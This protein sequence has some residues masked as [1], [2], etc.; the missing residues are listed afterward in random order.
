VLDLGVHLSPDFIVYKAL[1]GLA[2]EHPRDT[3]AVLRLMVLT[4]AEGWSLHGA[5]DETRD[6]LRLVLATDDEET[7]RD[8]QELVHLLGARGMTEFRDLVSN[9]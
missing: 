9:G 8:A 7:R 3:V 5:T 6:A 1:P 4:D 2:S